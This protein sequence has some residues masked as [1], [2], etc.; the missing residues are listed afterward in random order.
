MSLIHIQEEEKSLDSELVNGTVSSGDLVVRELGGGM[1]A[2]DPANDTV[3]NGVVPHLRVGD[4]I[5]EHDE[6]YR[7]IDEFTWDGDGTIGDSDRAPLQPRAESSVFVL[8]TIEDN[9]TDPAPAI[10]ENIGV[11]LAKLPDGT[12]GLVQRGYEDDAGTMY[13]FS[14]NGDYLPVG[15]AQNI[16]HGEVL[17]EFGMLIEVRLSPR[18]AP[19]DMAA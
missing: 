5:A 6:D 9:G 1:H 10:E 15:H 4:H 12:I 16:G 19:H 13:G 3:F 11:G 2:A 8:T 14:G 7:G 18:E 17:N